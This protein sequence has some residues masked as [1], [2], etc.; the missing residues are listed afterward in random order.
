MKA[1][2]RTITEYHFTFDALPGQTL[3]SAGDTEEKALKALKTKLQAV[4]AE[5]KL[6]EHNHASQ[7]QA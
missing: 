3:K 2:P 7:K 4:F 1:E 5:M 6:T